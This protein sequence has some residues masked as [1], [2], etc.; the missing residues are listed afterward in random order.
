[1]K[2]S[3]DCDLEEVGMKRGG[4]SDVGKNIPA[5]I[6]EVNDTANARKDLP[7]ARMVS[8]IL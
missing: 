4:L 3:E 7:T 1:M 5:K 6:Q 8:P 2:V